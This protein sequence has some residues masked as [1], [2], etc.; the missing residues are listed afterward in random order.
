MRIPCIT[1]CNLIAE[2]WFVCVTTKDG[3]GGLIHCS[4]RIHNPTRM[5]R[6]D[7]VLVR[8]SLEP[9][10]G[11]FRHCQPD[12][13]SV[14]MQTRLSVSQWCER[15]HRQHTARCKCGSQVT[16]GVDKLS[17]RPS[18]LRGIALPLSQIEDSRVIDFDVISHPTAC[19]RWQQNGLPSAGGSN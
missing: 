12:W 11:L 8:R 17:K 2:W 14:Y 9:T 6:K 18:Y 15:C 16:A 5:R 10:K 4:I 1:L 13:H 7:S 19:R 3:R